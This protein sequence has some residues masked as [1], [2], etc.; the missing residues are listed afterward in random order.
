MLTAENGN[1]RESFALDTSGTGSTRRKAGVTHV[2][3]ADI[4]RSSGGQ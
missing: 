3:T 1:L 2:V 4:G